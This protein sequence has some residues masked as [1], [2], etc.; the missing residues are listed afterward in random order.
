[1]GWK[2]K[3]AITTLLLGGLGFTGYRAY[4]SGYLEHVMS[5]TPIP[6]EYFR[7]SNRYSA[8][9]D[10]VKNA[11]RLP[12]AQYKEQV[13]PITS[14]FSGNEV[15]PDLLSEKWNALLDPIYGV[16]YTYVGSAR[17]TGL[18]QDKDGWSPLV[19]LAVYNDSEF[20]RNIT[21]KLVDGEPLVIRD[22]G[23]G[24]DYAELPDDFNMALLDLAT[25]SDDRFMEKKSWE[26]VGGGFYSEEDVTKL[27]ESDNHVKTRVLFIYSDSKVRVTRRYGTGTGLFQIDRSYD[28]DLL[29]SGKNTFLVP[30]TIKSVPVD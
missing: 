23:V 12:I 22:E 2:R 26:T 29:A 14:K 27:K 6:F 4:D 13:A 8:A 1:M 10:K 3:L 25:S 9:N 28:L 24:Y 15:R 5:T 30:M 20:V 17:L 21:I 19:T 18:I 16:E 7:V 11:E